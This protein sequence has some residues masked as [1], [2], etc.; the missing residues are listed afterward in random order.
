MKYAPGAPGT[1][2]RKSHIVS[3]IHVKDPVAPANTGD[4]PFVRRSTSSHFRKFASGKMVFIFFLIIKPGGELFVIT[5]ADCNDVLFIIAATVC[6]FPV[7]VKNK[8]QTEKKESAFDLYSVPAA[9]VAE[10]RWASRKPATE[11]DVS[12]KGLNV[13]KSGIDKCVYWTAAERA[14]YLTGR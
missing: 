13:R 6:F 14:E 7:S 4:F 12:I 3:P 10:R 8:K 1:A 2:R 5:H 9:S 11:L